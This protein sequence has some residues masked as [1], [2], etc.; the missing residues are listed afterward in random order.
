VELLARHFFTQHGGTDRADLTRF[1]A[2]TSDYSWPGNVRELSNAV[3]R[4]VALGDTNLRDLGDTPVSGN[5]E[6]IAAILD[7]GLPL[8]EARKRV[9]DELERRYVERVLA[10]HDGHIGKA[11]AA[12]GIARRYFELIRARQK[13]S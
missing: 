13:K 6:P 12:S 11:A 2:R 8:P 3:A 10:L 5:Q 9:V 1:L 4:H 7:L